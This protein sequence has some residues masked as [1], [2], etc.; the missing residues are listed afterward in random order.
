MEESVIKKTKALLNFGEHQEMKI[1]IDIPENKYEEIKNGIIKI[2]DGTLDIVEK[3][4]KDGVV[5]TSEE[6]F[7]K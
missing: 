5:I 2:S 6:N 1:I 7:L 3:A 4:I